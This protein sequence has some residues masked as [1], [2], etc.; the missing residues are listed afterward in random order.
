MKFASIVI[1]YREYSKIT[2]LK[3]V[4]IGRECYVLKAIGQLMQA[5]SV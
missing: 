1:F 3:W 2:Q 5:L 4:A